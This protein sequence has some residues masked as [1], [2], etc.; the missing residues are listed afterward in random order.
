MTTNQRR[1]C[2]KCK[3]L[4]DVHY[5]AGHECCA[6]CKH[7]MHLFFTLRQ[8][9]ALQQ[10]FEGPKRI[11]SA[12]VS[13]LMWRRKG[14]AG[15]VVLATE[16]GLGLDFLGPAPS[17]EFWHW[18]ELEVAHMLPEDN[19]SLEVMTPPDSM[20]QF[21]VGDAI[22]LQ[23][24]KVLWMKRRVNVKSGPPKWYATT[25]LGTASVLITVEKLRTIVDWLPKE[26]ALA[27]AS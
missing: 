3:K 7:F 20:W 24:G 9:A 6:V 14:E 25:G 23:S 12:Q 18:D 16:H 1:Y 4:A 13:E 27:K 17:I 5:E 21:S 10:M 22:M 8:R 15:S 19:P 26:I 2:R 11:T